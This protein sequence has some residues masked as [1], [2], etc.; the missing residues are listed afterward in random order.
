MARRKIEQLPFLLILVSLCFFLHSCKPQEK[1]VP[2]P[3]IVMS[4]Y[5]LIYPYAKN[6]SWIA[7]EKTYEVTFTQDGQI[8]TIVFTP[9]G[10]VDR[11]KLNT[12]KM[13]LPA[14]VKDYVQ[15]NF[16]GQDIDQV[17]KVVNGFGTAT[18]EVTVGDTSC[19]F[20]S[21]G[22]FM[23]LIWNNGNPE[24]GAAK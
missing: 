1:T 6:P 7:Y 18:W 15:E 10:A 11:T 24:K 4:R 17:L 23:G 8:W 13:P 9:D 19:L 14:L 3:D 20:S 2:V 22:H 12:G 5:K 21:D 16:A